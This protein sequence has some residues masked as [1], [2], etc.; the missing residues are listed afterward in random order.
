MTKIRP[1]FTRSTLRRYFVTRTSA[2]LRRVLRSGDRQT[3]YM[4]YGILVERRNDH[5][6]ARLP[7]SET[8]E[9]TKS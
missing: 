1:T 6:A 5:S 2:A 3:R 7:P 9:G 8:P 4:A